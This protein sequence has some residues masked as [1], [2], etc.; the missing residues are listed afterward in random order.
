AAPADRLVVSLNLVLA[1]TCVYPLSRWGPGRGEWGLPFLRFI[2]AVAVLLVLGLAVPQA[3]AVEAVNVRL[4]VAATD[5]TDAV[6]RPR[7][8]GEILQVSTAPGADG[9]VRRIGV[10]AR[11]PGSSWAVFALANSSDEQIDRLIVVPHYRMVGSGFL[12]PDL[13]LSRVV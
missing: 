12:W 5:L 2:N 4:D 8:D 10:R 3:H 13:G 7:T 11:E 1:T 9:I 6:E